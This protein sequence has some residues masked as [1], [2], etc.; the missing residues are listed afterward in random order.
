[1]RW[2]FNPIALAHFALGDDKGRPW[3]DSWAAVED[4]FQTAY[5]SD[6]DTV[7]YGDADT[8][9]LVDLLESVSA[10]V[11]K[12]VSVDEALAIPAVRALEMRLGNP[13][14]LP[15]LLALVIPIV[16]VDFRPPGAAGFPTNTHPHIGSY[17]K[18]GALAVEGISWSDPEQGCTADCYLIASMIAI[19]WT[20][21]KKWRKVLADASEQDKETLNVQFHSPLSGQA[22]PKPI[23]VP[24]KV[25]RSPGGDWI[26]ARS[27]NKDETWPAL[28]ER[29]F[30]MLRCKK[31]GEPTVGDYRAIGEDSTVVAFPHE[32]AR[33]LIGG[34]PIAQRAPQ[35][36]SMFSFVVDR[37]NGLLT[38]SP[39]I[40]WTW[41]KKD[42]NAPVRKEW[43]ASTL[44]QS[45]AYAVLGL[46]EKD[47]R[48]F[49]V[50][51]NPYGFNP[52]VPDSPKAPWAAGAP[53]NGGASVSFDKKGGVIAI[54]EERFNQFF[55]AVGGVD[56][57]PGDA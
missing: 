54:S 21:P 23:P 6:A 29:G 32:A 16:G 1:M 55:H 36:K 7:F 9:A 34:L 30:V 57:L 8:P 31:S 12:E 40:A 25:P 2:A 45:H 14:W 22:D 20:R 24:A 33:I 10:Q 53:R 51:R 28:I 52:P 43:K 48:K 44:I 42:E 5:G 38:E 15:R 46:L 13:D 49:V 4:L 50:L 18:I 56:D 27:A 39:T 11:P 26:Y 19:A 41:D 35:A 47:G 3:P 17:Q 37:C